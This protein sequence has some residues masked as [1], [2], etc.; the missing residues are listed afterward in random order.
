MNLA[1]KF[2]VVLSTLSLVLF[3]GCSKQNLDLSKPDTIVKSIDK[4]SNIVIDLYDH[5]NA[6]DWALCAFNASDYASFDR[7]YKNPLP[8]EFADSLTVENFN[9]GF[10]DEWLLGVIINSQ[11]GDKFYIVFQTDEKT[12]QSFYW[13]YYEEDKSD[14]KISTKVS[15]TLSF[16]GLK[17]L[18]SSSRYAITV[19]KSDGSTDEFLSKGFR[20][21][22]YIKYNSRISS[23]DARNHVPVFEKN[24]SVIKQ[25]IS[26]KGW[27]HNDWYVHKLPNGTYATFK[28]IE[29][30]SNVVRNN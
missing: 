3:L 12:F 11:S 10:I 5:Y 1:R 16:N 20:K 13:S 6:F 15:P 29:T 28:G 17:K 18:F 7:I 23:S 30:T 4:K 9:L 24:I 21:F 25:W 14:G 26:D 2:F 22:D 27:E 19:E 8:I